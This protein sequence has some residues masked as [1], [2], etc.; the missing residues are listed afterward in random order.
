[1]AGLIAL[2]GFGKA[3]YLAGVFTSW[4]ACFCL[5]R[6]DAVLCC[7]FIALFSSSPSSRFMMKFSSS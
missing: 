5:S 1:M 2:A 3:D 4:G 7:S 6:S